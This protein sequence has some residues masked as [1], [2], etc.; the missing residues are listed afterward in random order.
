MLSMFS[1]AASTYLF[2]GSARVPVDGPLSYVAFQDFFQGTS[3]S[4]L[5]V[6][7][8]QYV[9]APFADYVFALEC[10]SAA[11]PVFFYAFQ[12]CVGVLLPGKD[13]AVLC[14]FF[15]AS[16]SIPARMV[17]QCWFSHASASTDGLMMTAQ[18]EPGGRTFSLVI[19]PVCRY[20]HLDGPLSQFCEC[21]HSS[22]QHHRGHLSPE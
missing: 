8:P 15:S 11:G 18:P 9:G 10:D 14:L 7:R 3:A 19:A 22:G 4:F 17:A 5:G 2:S 12:Y 6:L 13:L 1:T 16:M 21:P 20:G